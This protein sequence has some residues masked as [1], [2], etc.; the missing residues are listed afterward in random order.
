MA[1][2]EK[3][4]TDLMR[5]QS[6]SRPEAE[7]YQGFLD[8]PPRSFNA[9][10]VPLPLEP[11]TIPITRLSPGTAKTFA[12]IFREVHQQRTQEAEAA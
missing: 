1:N 10:N 2:R 6:L 3:R 11:M 12:R 4:I 8:L 7:A 5:D 9:V